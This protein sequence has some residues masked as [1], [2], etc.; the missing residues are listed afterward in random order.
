[1]QAL[2][3]VLGAFFFATMGVGVK[4]ASSS[5][6]TFEIVRNGGAIVLC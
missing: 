4:L 6:N 2:W 1:M 5:F 3:M